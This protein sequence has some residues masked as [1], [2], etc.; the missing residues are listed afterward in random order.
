MKLPETT[1]LPYDDIIE[2]PSPTVLEDFTEIKYFEDTEN[3][4]SYSIKSEDFKTIYTK[5]DAAG[6]ETVYELRNMHNS[7]A[8]FIDGTVYLV[9]RASEL[10]EIMDEETFEITSIYNIQ[11][12]SAFYE[13]NEP[14][15]YKV[16]YRIVD[17]KLHY[18][19]TDFADGYV[20][21]KEYE[22]VKQ[23]VDMELP[24]YTHYRMMHVVLIAAF[25]LMPITNVQ[26]TT[27]YIDFKSRYSKK[28]Q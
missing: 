14:T 22:L 12:K 13:G 20:Y 15:D 19:Q 9:F 8:I 24:F 28:E 6:N 17:N 5:T 7:N 26:S 1:P 4:L 25:M 16:Y 2:F 18:I 23:D 21:I 11:P 3:N 27:T 10:I